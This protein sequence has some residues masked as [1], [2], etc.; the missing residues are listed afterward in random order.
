MAECIGIPLRYK[1][2]SGVSCN[3]NLFLMHCTPFII[4]WFLFIHFSLFQSTVISQIF[5]H[6]IRGALTRGGYCTKEIKK[7]IAI[8]KETSNRKILFSARNLDIELRKKF[9]RWYVWNI[10][11]YGSEIWTLRKLDWKYSLE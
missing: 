10:F 6:T 3:F 9:V 2:I 11:L 7:R 8:A 5:S 1:V 4:P